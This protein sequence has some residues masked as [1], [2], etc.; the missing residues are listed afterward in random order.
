MTKVLIILASITALLIILITVLTLTNPPKKSNPAGPNIPTSS[1]SPGPNATASPN[2]PLSV[3]QSSP[4]NNAEDVLLYAPISLHF[5]KTADLSQAKVSISPNA[6][7]QISNNAQYLDITPVQALQPN[8]QYKVVVS[9]PQNNFSYTLL[10]ATGTN[11]VT[12]SGPSV[13]AVQQYDNQVRQTNPSLFLSNEVPYSNDLFAIDLGPFKT[14]PNSH[15]SFIVTL[16]GNDKQA[17][18]NSLQ[19][20]LKSLQLN[21]SQ[22]KGLDVTYK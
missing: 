13:E 14:S 21:D 4:K 17:S 10:F 7:V 12:S 1:S 11:A 2:A 22:I 8:T 20:W 5:N 9:I 15:Y 3:D 6:N 19:S 16:K 18:Q